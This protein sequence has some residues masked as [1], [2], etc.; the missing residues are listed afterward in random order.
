[1]KKLFT[2]HPSSIGETYLQHL[3]YAGVFGLQMM[4]GG[5]ACV[6]HAIFPF[7]FKDTASDYLLRMTEKFIRRLPVMQDRVMKIAKA[8]EEKNMEVSSNPLV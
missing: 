5:L 2:D 1:M 3:Y 6:I 4:I 8:I 7:L